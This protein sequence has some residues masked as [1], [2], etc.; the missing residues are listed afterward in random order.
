MGNNK[1]KTHGEYVAEVKALNPNIEVVGIYINSKTKILHRCKI[2]GYKWY[3][4][5]ANILS[6]KG[7]PKCG[8]NLKRTHE[9]YVEIINESYPYIEVTGTYINNKTPISHKCKIHNYEWMTPPSNILSGHLCKKCA[10]DKLYND[11]V[12]SHDEYVEDVKNISPNIIVVGT[13]INTMTAILHRCSI[14]NYEWMVRPNNILSGTG[15]PMCSGIIKKTHEQYCQEVSNVNP[16]IEVV[17]T[18]I[19]ANTPIEHKCLIHNIIWNTTPSNILRNAGCQECMKM[20]IS[21]ANTHTHSQYLDKLYE[22]NSNIKVL[23][24]YIDANTP[25]KHMCL[26]CNNEWL[27]RPSNILNGKGCPRCN[28]SH[29]EKEIALL[30]DKYN[31]SYETQYKFNDCKDKKVLP[32][33]FYLPTYHKLIEYQGKQHYE[34]IEFFGG[35]DAFEIRQKHD[36]IKS[37]YCKN[38]GIPLLCIPYDKNIEEEL[39]NFLFN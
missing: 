7:C 37:E 24:K 26:I 34:P 3:A 11:R 6:G 14:D 39:N 29:G 12:K 5:P 20:K 32:F 25:I 2:D 4:Q 19:N 18:Y 30:L 17:G 31:I 8:G 36:N 35:Q 22:R 13:Y 16:N 15:C 1:R 27:A 38:N 21:E 23:E 10:S 9:E 33:D 28:Q